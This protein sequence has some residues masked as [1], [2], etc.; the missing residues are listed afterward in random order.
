MFLLP[1]WK[2]HRE[3]TVPIEGEDASFLWHIPISDAEWEYRK[4]H[5]VDGLI[6]RMQEVELPRIFDESERQPM[7]S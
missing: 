4:E 7:V 1:L 3:F 2:T 6:D 5:G